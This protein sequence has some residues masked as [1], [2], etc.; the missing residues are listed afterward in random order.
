[1]TRSHVI[2]AN[3]IGIR[4]GTPIPPYVLRRATELDMFLQESRL[5]SDHPVVQAQMHAIV[6]DWQTVNAAAALERNALTV[7]AA[8]GK[9]A[10]AP[11]ASR[12]GTCSRAVW[13]ALSA[14]WTGRPDADALPD[15]I[16]ARA[17]EVAWLLQSQRLPPEHPA[18]RA[19]AAR[20]AADCRAQTAAGAARL[21]AAALRSWQDM[22]CWSRLLE[23]LKE[24]AGLERRMDDAGKK[25]ETASGDIWQTVR[26]WFRIT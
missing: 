9:K 13:T 4:N 26:Q 20:I 18:V 14:A 11:P 16:L 7:L 21:A 19:C 10:P 5:P 6:A 25:S 22:S 17:G 8:M 3:A 1:M 24:C 15:A 2:L 23:C 12:Q